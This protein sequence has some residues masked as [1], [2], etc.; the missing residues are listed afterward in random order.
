MSPFFQPDDLPV[1]VAC[2]TCS[3]F[4]SGLAPLRDAIL[5]EQTAITFEEIATGMRVPLSRCRHI[6]MSDSGPDRTL[7]LAQDCLVEDDY[8]SL[9]PWND[10]AP[11]RRG[12]AVATSKGAFLSFLRADPPPMHEAAPDAVAR[13]LARELVARGPI[14]ARVAACATGAMNLIAACDWV[15]SGTADIVLAGSAEA[16]LHPLYF[17]SFAGLGLLTTQGCRPYDS[18]RD[19]FAIGEGAALFQVMRE[20]MARS[21]GLRILARV[22]GWASAAEAWAMTGMEPSGE[23]IE[24][25]ARKALGMVRVAPDDLDLIQSHG[26]ATTSNDTAEIA[27]VRLLETPAPLCSLKGALGHLMGSAAGVEIAAC[28]AAIADGFIP[29]TVGCED[30]AAPDVRVQLCSERRVPKCILKVSAGFGGQI[31]AVVLTR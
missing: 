7:V 27:F 13:A 18:R 22:P 2:R 8:W 3:P 10:T 23:L 9:A 25:C 5:A 12:V 19:G 30:Q 28:V 15:A 14:Q 6:P 24:K 16:A 29:G 20:S 4:G 21:R 1:I 11:E 26:T 31:A 17:A